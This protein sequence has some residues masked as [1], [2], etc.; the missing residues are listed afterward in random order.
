MSGLSSLWIQSFSTHPVWCCLIISSGFLKFNCL[1]VFLDCLLLHSSRFTFQV[2]F[3][4]SWVCSE[5]SEPSKNSVHIPSGAYQTGG[6]WSS[7]DGGRSWTPNL[8]WKGAW[9][10]L[11]LEIDDGCQ[12]WE[13]FW[14][15]LCSF[16]VCI[17]LCMGNLKAT[18]SFG[19]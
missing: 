14:S 8:P 5:S 15:I 2:S 17:I 12:I 19:K 9:K 3:L 18:G 11:Q 6:C 7:L 10:L 4:N 13:Y 16:H 1:F